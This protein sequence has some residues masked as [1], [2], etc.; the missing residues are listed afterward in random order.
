MKVVPELRT[1]RR[2]DRSLS[3][4][5]SPRVLCNNFKI[6]FVDIES[7]EPGLFVVTKR[8]KWTKHAITMTY[9]NLVLE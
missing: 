1:T 3:Q 7:R 4:Y 8:E 5:A 9:S 2:L 6:E